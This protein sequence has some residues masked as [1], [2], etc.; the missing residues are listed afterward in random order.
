MD[1]ASSSETL[2]PYTNLHDVIFQ[3]KEIFFGICCCCTVVDDDDDD[4]DEL[5]L[6][7]QDPN[8]Y[9]LSTL[10]K[11]FCYVYQSAQCPDK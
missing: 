7:P 6:F 1:E 9:F 3:S 5:L 2:V 10:V 4:D 11:I 8:A